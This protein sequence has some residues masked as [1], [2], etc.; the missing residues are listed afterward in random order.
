MLFSA[1]S[2][3]TIHFLFLRTIAIK[4]IILVVLVN[5]EASTLLEIAVF[6]SDTLGTRDTPRTCRD[7]YGTRNMACH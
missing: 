1:R 7:I 2:P 6:M 3:W 5:Y 4:E